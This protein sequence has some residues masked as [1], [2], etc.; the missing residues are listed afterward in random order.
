MTLKGAEALMLYHRRG[1]EV[2]EFDFL[3]FSFERKEKNKNYPCGKNENCIQSY[4]FI[5]V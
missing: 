5:S 2:A 4:G 1:A 3:L